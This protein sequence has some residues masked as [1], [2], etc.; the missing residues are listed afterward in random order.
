MAGSWR[1]GIHYEPPEVAEAV[2]PPSSVRFGAVIAVDGVLVRVVVRDPV[3]LPEA[4]ER[5][6]P[7]D[8]VAEA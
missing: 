3:E 5:L 1:P 6:P 2:P 4:P 7:E 8:G